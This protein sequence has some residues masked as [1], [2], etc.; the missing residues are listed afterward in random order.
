MNYGQMQAR[1]LHCGLILLSCILHF[2][3]FCWTTE[4]KQK[5]CKEITPV[6][7]LHCILYDLTGFWN[8]LWSK[9]RPKM[10]RNGS[11]WSQKFHSQISCQNGKQVTQKRVQKMLE[12]CSW[13][14]PETT[15]IGV[16]FPNSPKNTVEMKSCLFC[17]GLDHVQGQL[18]IWRL[19]YT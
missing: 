15:K 8:W 12:N 6:P 2:I 14:C 19:E 16:S 17:L 9:N 11:N 5:F 4:I 18:Y 13:K 10:A 1:S 3:L 7:F